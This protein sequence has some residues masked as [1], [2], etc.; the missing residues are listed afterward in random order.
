[1]QSDKW[2]LMFAANNAWKSSCKMLIEMVTDE[3]MPEV[4]HYSTRVIT[5][6]MMMITTQARL[7]CWES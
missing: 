7:T 2:F 1:M 4:N 5:M 6:K 3:I